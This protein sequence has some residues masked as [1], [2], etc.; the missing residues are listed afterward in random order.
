MLCSATT[1]LAQ[2]DEPK[3]GLVQ[4]SQTSVFEY[5]LVAAL[6]ALA[7]FAICRTSHRS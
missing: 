7:L 6:F 3:S 5:I 2:A 1:A 4:Q